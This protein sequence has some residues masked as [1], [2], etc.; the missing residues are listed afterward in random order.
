MMTAWTAKALRAA[1]DRRVRSF[2]TTNFKAFA[3]TGGIGLAKQVYSS[4]SRSRR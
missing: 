2:L 1:S 4:C 3:K